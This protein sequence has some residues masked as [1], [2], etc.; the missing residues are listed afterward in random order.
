MTFRLA[1]AFPG[2]GGGIGAGGRGGGVRTGGN[3]SQF[4]RDFLE[5]EGILLK[6]GVDLTELRIQFYFL[7][8]ELTLKI[9]DLGGEGVLFGLVL[10]KI[11]VENAL[12]GIGKLV[13]AGGEIVGESGGTGIL[14]EI[15]D[16]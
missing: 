9:G 2:R 11:A 1:C 13:E 16:G 15:F 8:R 3:G 5:Q 14:E 6:I 7:G 4:L 12:R 10:V